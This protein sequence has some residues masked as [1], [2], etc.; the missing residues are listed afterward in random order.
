MNKKPNRG[1]KNDPQEIYLDIGRRTHVLNLISFQE[2]A[3]WRRLWQISIR[4]I[5]ERLYR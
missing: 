4:S 1:K 2:V 5:N 3:R